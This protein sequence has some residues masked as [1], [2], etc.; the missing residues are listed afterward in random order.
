MEIGEFN[1]KSGKLIQAEKAIY[2]TFEPNPLPFKINYDEELIK[3]LAEAVASIS[4]LSGMGRKLRDPNLLITPYLKKEAVLSSEIEGTRTS[5]SEV[6]LD[7][8]EKEKKKSKDEDLKEVNN[9]IRALEQGLEEIKT[10]EISE[11]LIR[12]LHRILLTSVRGADKEPGIFKT[13]Q[14]HLGG[15]EDIMTANFIP[16]SPKTT[17]KLMENLIDYINNYDKSHH[18]IKAGIMHY[19]FETIHPF[20]DGNGRMGRL[21]ITLFLCKNKVLSKPLLYLSA[22]F[23]K[24]QKE[25]NQKLFDVSSKGHIEDWLKFFL[26]AIKAQSEDALARTIELDNYYEDA[27]KILEKNSSS[28]RALLVLD[29]L[30]E[31]PFIKITEIEK[32]LSCRY[33]TAK[34]NLNILVKNGILTEHNPSKEKREKIFYCKRISDILEIE[35]IMIEGHSHSV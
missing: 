17:P 3:L 27:R 31:N 18:L 29:A 19:Q 25:Y 21:L 15:T 10:G 7:E 12:K 26:K 35:N 22:Y 2:S 8:K 20:R 13:H 11:E 16:A 32:I 14:N 6:L 34:N 9:Y 4:D 23:K 33:P 30:F 5:L 1:G 24:Y 28:T